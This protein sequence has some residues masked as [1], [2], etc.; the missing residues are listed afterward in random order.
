MKAVIGLGNPGMKYAGTR[1]NIGFD[2][3]TAI[4]DKYNLKI[5]NRK[6]KGMYAETFI[7]GEK[8]LLVQ[9]QT[10]MNLSG[11]CVRE[12]CDF[13]KLLPE[14]VIIICD[15]INLDTGRI[16]IRKKGSAG[17]H[18]GLKNIIA[19]LGTEEFPRIRVGAG[20]KPENWD[21]VDFVLGRFP[22]DEEP[23][24]REALLNV[25]AAVETW[26]IDGID[27][28]MNR[29]NTPSKKKE[30]KEE[31]LIRHAAGVTPSPQGEGFSGGAGTGSETGTGASDGAGADSGGTGDRDGNGTGTGT[32]T[33]D[34]A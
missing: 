10:F 22:K 32:G 5:N 12:I 21:Q 7:G 34:G 18:N 31:H 24:I 15:D 27:T 30:V 11:E 28:A 1:H 14:E 2:A 17:G 13:Y 3:V 26:V 4:A 19:H 8:V 9:P 25:V 23:V 20:E 33:G 16:R 29:Y 6:F